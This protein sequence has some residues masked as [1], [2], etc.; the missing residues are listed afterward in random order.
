MPSLKPNAINLIRCGAE[1]LIGEGNEGMAYAL[2][3]LAN[4]LLTVMNGG[5]TLEEWNGIYTT[6]LSD[7]LD[8]DE[9]MPDPSD[10][11]EIE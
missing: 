5:A 3:E 9:H 2:H 4:N 11:G 8:L 1:A 7:H 6:G 10:D